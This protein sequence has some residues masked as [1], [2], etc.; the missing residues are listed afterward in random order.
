MKKEKEVDSNKGA[1]ITIMTVP[2]KSIVSVA[3]GTNNILK[4]DRCAILL[5]ALDF[6]NKM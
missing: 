4:G 2:S 1:T 5:K 3:T 6:L